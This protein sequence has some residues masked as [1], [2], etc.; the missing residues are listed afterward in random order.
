MVKPSVHRS[1]DTNS[2]RRQS[3]DQVPLL[4]EEGEESPE[5]PAEAPDKPGMRRGIVETAMSFLGKLFKTLVLQV[6]KWS[7]PG[8]L[9]AVLFFCY[10]G[11]G[12]WLSLL[13]FITC[14]GLFYNAQDLLLYYPDQPDSSRIFV[15][16]PAVLGIDC[17]GFEN[18]FIETS[19]GIKINAFLFKHPPSVSP[20]VPT[21]LF[22]HGNAGNIGHR[23]VNAVVFHSACHCNVLLVE[24][25]GFGKS[26]GEPSEEGLYRDAQAALNY[27]H[28]RSDINSKL[29]FVFGRSLGGA[30]A[31][32]LACNP[33]NRGGIRGLIIENTFT[34]IPD[35]GRCLFNLELLRW[36][37]HGIVK[38]KY[39][40]FRK[41]S[42]VKV[43]TLFLSGAADE[44]VPPA[45]MNALYERCSAPKKMAVF[46]NGSHNDTW[47]VPGYSD[48]VRDHIARHSGMTV[49]NAS[50]HNP[51]SANLSRHLVRGHG[52]H[53]ETPHE[54]TN[55]NG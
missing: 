5:Q 47:Q 8:M 21:I 42:S 2:Q 16:N 37:P 38:N 29:I 9:I 54:N 36:I 32:D 28:N 24:Y 34:S 13:V 25:R 4:Q 50:R 26:E 23:L 14:L 11:G 40:S 33:K 44:L 39:F 10:S 27:L 35:M 18:I 22:F 1:G 41:I 46:E 31:I 48:I 7:S 53:S 49:N 19:D 15:P 45:M 12:V 20:M 52:R 3:E 43:P 17:S 51:D 6:W 30:V 55:S